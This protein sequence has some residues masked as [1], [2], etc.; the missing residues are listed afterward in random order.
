MTTSEERSIWSPA[1]VKCETRSL[2]CGV[3]RNTYT[4]SLGS[5][6]SASASSKP[7][8]PLWPA[9]GSTPAG[10]DSSDPL[11][12]TKT[13]PLRSVKS[14]RPSPKGASAV[15]STCG[16]TMEVLVKPTGRAVSLSGA[17]LELST[18]QSVHSPSPLAP[19]F[20]TPAGAL[21]EVAC[22]SA[23]PA[24][25]SMRQEPTNPAVWGGTA[26]FMSASTSVGRRAT[27]KMRNSSSQPRQAKGADGPSSREPPT[28]SSFA[29][30]TNA[31]RPPASGYDRSRCVPGMVAT[32]S[33]TPSTMRD[34]RAFCTSRTMAT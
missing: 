20:K 4:A 11:R 18:L 33:N 6:G 9:T 16:G 23:W 24:P 2:S 13:V 34:R 15:G 22:S 12:K 25:S 8:S 1:R 31:S 7:R 3:V 30:G 21:V 32:A 26:R 29:A 28:N 19:F 10:C 5:S 27:S 17:Q 14:T